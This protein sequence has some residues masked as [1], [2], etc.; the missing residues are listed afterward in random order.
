MKCKWL[1]VFFVLV[2]AVMA[3]GVDKCQ[4]NSNTAT[5]TAIELGGYNLGYYIG[6]SKTDA[7]DIAIA[8]AYRLARTG[9]LSPE[10]VSKAFAKL[11]IE[12]PQLS[13]SLLIVLKSMGAGFDMEGNLI[14]LS[15]IPVEYWDKAAEG[16]VVGYEFGKAGQKSVKPSAVKAVMPKK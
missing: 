4:I 14:S 12:N 1:S 3:M 7:D 8:D 15:G 2:I 11:K 16:Y 13:G 9:Q 6:K 5:L 10:E